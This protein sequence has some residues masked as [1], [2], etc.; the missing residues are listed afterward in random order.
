MRISL[1][2][3]VVLG[4]CF[5]PSDLQAQ[6][7][8]TP[9]EWEEQSPEEVDLNATA[10]RA[11]VSFAQANEYSGERDLRLAILQ[12]FSREPGHGLRG[13]V[14]DRGGPAGM[15][16]K[17]GYVI[18]SWGDTERVDM[19][20][21]VTK[22]YLS[23]TAGL[24]LAE[25]L[26]DDL[27]DSVLHYVWDG[28]YQGEHNAGI[29]WEHL[30]HQTS[31]WSG[32]LFGLD[33]WTDRPDR[34]SGYDE[35]KQRELYAPGEY[36]KYNDVRVNLLA[37]SLLQVWRRPLPQ[38]LKERVMDPIGA[39][40]TWR[41][42]GYDDSWTMIDGLHMQSVSGGGHHGGGVF[43]STEDHAR[44]GLLFARG[45]QVEQRAATAG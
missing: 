23:T 32:T 11:A 6:Y 3:L 9:T 25:G 17:D 7:Y 45:W 28:T 35:W 29:T 20:F 40:P 34:E 5:T 2:L 39:S 36:Y 41:W 1:Y 21:S 16:I 19:S 43:M 38:V 8:P 15:V 27:Q 22:S 42:F 37:Y 13:P 14:K 44:F 4:F 30:L 33:D 10:L 26:I 12:G 18:A 31:D 24:A